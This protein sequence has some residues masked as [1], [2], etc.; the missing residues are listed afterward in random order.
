MSLTE[1]EK[2]LPA[3]VQAM[4]MATRKLESC[5]ITNF[6]TNWRRNGRAS[7]SSSATPHGGVEQ[8]EEVEKEEGN[9]E[10]GVKKSTASVHRD[11]PWNPSRTFI[12][13][14]SYML[15]NH[16]IDWKQID[17]PEQWTP[18]GKIHLPCAKRYTVNELAPYVCRVFAN[19]KREQWPDWV[20]AAVA[21]LDKHPNTGE[22]PKKRG[23][24]PKADK[25][26]S[27]AM[28][29]AVAIKSPSPKKK[30]VAKKDKMDVV[31]LVARELGSSARVVPKTLVTPSMLKAQKKKAQNGAGKL[32]TTKKQKGKTITTST[33]MNVE[34]VGLVDVVMGEPPV[35]TAQSAAVTILTGY[36][37]DVALKVRR[38]SKGDDG[39]SGIP[40]TYSIMQGVRGSMFSECLEVLAKQCDSPVFI[41]GED[42]CR[43][44][45][46]GIF[47]SSS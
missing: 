10:E 33:P 6:D 5:D 30:K 21:W 45:W 36:I 42:G 18:E 23:P 7:T 19:D 25:V 34:G 1:V 12:K 15:R 11:D 16:P 13:L 47:H 9:E 32:L 43:F 4:I 14:R 8:E 20:R 27:P 2:T 31:E 44:S 3:E 28:E 37:S 17:L 29:A 40:I 39:K 38:A 24:R 22:P 26:T 35:R 41:W 46:K